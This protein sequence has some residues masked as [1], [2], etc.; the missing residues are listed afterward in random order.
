M[1]CWALFMT[2]MASFYK[3]DVYRHLVLRQ[4][5]STYTGAADGHGNGSALE[6]ADVIG[7]I[8]YE[9]GVSKMF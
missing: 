7:L 3:L 4:V 9:G 6:Q 2:V 1:L 5:Y 8:K